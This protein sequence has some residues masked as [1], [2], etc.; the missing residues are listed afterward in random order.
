MYDDIDLSEDIF[1]I[2]TGSP[3]VSQP[4]YMYAEDEMYSPDEYMYMDDNGNIADRLS[5][6]G[7]GDLPD[8][9]P[10]YEQISVSD[11]FDQCV[12]PTLSQAFSSVF[13][14]LTLCFV[15]RLT[16]LFMSRSMY[17]FSVN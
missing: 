15:F 12:G 14:L 17:I 4:E 6:L 8:N 3:L 11:L 1:D 13:P 2:D 9:V 7:V 5:D 16:C 10:Y